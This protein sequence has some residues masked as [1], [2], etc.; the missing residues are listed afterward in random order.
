MD[1][2]EVADPD[3]VHT[4]R[5]FIRKQLA[6]E[7]KKE[8]ISAVCIFLPKISAR[9][10]MCYKLQPNLHSLFSCRLQTIGALKSMFS[11]ILIW[12]GVL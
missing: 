6:R 7:L 8:L 1:L 4:V 11:I 10:S 2:M 12:P 9:S 3:A 5:D